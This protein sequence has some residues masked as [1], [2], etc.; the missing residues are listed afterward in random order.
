MSARKQFLGASIL[1]QTVSC[2]RRYY[3]K[4]KTKMRFYAKNGQIKSDIFQV[5]E[6]KDKKYGKMNYG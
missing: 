2:V 1:P 3:H 4:L 6:L 5:Y